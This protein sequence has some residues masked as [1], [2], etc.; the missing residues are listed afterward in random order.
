[1]ENTPLSAQELRQALHPGEFVNF[2]DDRSVKSQVL[3]KIFKNKNTNNGDFRM[4]DVELL[5]RYVAFYYFLSK[6]DGNIKLFLNMTCESLNNKW[7]EKKND[8]ENV[9][10]QF[11]NAVEATIFI[12]GDKNFSRV[13]DTTKYRS[14]FNRAT[15]ENLQKKIK[16]V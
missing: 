2:L 10:D 4:R 1:M 3:K 13:W 16:R 12:F 14:Q 5:L 7:S 9:V 6:Y 8:I 15:S 11:E